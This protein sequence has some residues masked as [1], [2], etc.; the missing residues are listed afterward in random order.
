MLDSNVWVSISEAHSIAKQ[1]DRNFP[2]VL[3][4]ASL[5]KKELVLSRRRHQHEP[6]LVSKV[7]HVGEAQGFPSCASPFARRN[8]ISRDQLFIDEPRVF[9]VRDLPQNVKHI[10]P[11]HVSNSKLLDESL[12]TR[13]LTSVSHN[14]RA[15]KGEGLFKR[16]I[17]PQPK[18]WRWSLMKTAFAASSKT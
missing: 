2:C 7:L 16:P 9:S 6:I 11:C 3:D 10:P 15:P 5:Q 13:R 18:P 1:F 4:L 14:V 17:P 12:D 8:P